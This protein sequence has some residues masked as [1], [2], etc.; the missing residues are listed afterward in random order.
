MLLTEEGITTLVVAVGT[1]PH[2]L[3]AVFQ[4]VLV[5]PCQVPVAIT[6][7]RTALETIEQPPDVTTL[8]NQV[9]TETADGE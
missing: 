8:L 1:P 9:L 5:M 3:D 4:P 2:Q 6:D 7:T